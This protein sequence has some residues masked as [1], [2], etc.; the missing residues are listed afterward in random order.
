MLAEN[1]I[2]PAIQF[3]F[4]IDVYLGMKSEVRDLGKLLLSLFI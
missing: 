4:R 3:C 2:W 1:L